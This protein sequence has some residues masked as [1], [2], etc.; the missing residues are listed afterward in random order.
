MLDISHVYH[1]PLTFTGNPHL[2]TETVSVWLLGGWAIKISIIPLPALW[3]LS[4]LSVKRPTP[5]IWCKVIRGESLNHLLLTASPGRDPAGGYE[6]GHT[7]DTRAA[8]S[9]SS[10]CVT[11]PHGLDRTMVPAMQGHAGAVLGDRVSARGCGWQGSPV[12]GGVP[13]G[14]W[15]RMWLSE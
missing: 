13:Q 4:K 5:G 6:D 9:D 12:N 2:R 8:E 3:G 14:S 7:Q 1:V 11:E 15:G 10:L